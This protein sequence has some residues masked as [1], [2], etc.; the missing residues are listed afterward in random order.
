MLSS[1]SAG[2][3]PSLM[4]KVVRSAPSAPPGEPCLGREML[5]QAPRELLDP[6]RQVLV[7]EVGVMSMMLE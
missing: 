5:P 7:P 2:K 3:I 6:G 1:E 4:G